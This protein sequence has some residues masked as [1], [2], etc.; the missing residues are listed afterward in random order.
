MDER[1]ELIQA[2]YAERK[3][4]RHLIK[5]LIQCCNLLVQKVAD[6]D[7]SARESAN[8]IIRTS[9]AFLDKHFS[10]D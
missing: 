10:E 6:R 7:T 8:E 4:Y 5:M 1:D 9:Q 2:L 3:I